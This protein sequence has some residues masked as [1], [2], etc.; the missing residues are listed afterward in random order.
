MRMMVAY[1]YVPAYILQRTD[2]G[3]RPERPTRLSIIVN[4]LS[5]LI[6]SASIPQLPSKRYVLKNGPA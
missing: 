5:R 4:A 6:P 3:Y 2:E 1:A